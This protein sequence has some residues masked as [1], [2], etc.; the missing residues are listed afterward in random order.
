MKKRKEGDARGE[1]CAGPLLDV[2][3]GR[4]QRDDRRAI[5]RVGRSR[6]QFQS[7]TYDQRKIIRG[8]AFLIRAAELGG[9]ERAGRFRVTTLRSLINAVKQTRL[10]NWRIIDIGITGRAFERAKR[11]GR[12]SDTLKLRKTR[13]VTTKAFIF[14]SVFYPY[15]TENRLQ[16]RICIECLH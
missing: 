1:P 10:V 3:H 12:E 4:T 9:G 7:L 11:V 8:S 14:S 6:S 2:K 5:S 13:A 15:L 16:A